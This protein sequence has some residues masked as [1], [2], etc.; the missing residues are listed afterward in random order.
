MVLGW[1][2]MGER[3]TTA[4]NTDSLP[5]HDLWSASLA[6]AVNDRNTL[7]LRGENLAN[8]YYVL[9]PYYPMPGRT[10]AAS[11]AVRF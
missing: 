6:Y 5:A 8:R 7:S 9:Q 2:L 10:F 4:Q 11:W 1:S 3:F